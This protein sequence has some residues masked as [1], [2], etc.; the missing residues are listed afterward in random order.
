MV[1]RTQN[2]MRVWKDENSI[3]WCSYFSSRESEL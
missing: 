3:M 1:G 2:D